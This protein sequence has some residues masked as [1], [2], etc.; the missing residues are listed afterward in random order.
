M[1]VCF[2]DVNKKEL[3]AVRVAG[4]EGV[5]IFHAL[6]NATSHP[7]FNYHTVA[8]IEETTAGKGQ[9]QREQECK[10]T[11]RSGGHV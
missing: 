10:L 7:H 4:I 3:S 8:H 1:R 11:S 9:G 6:Q 2:H 5:E